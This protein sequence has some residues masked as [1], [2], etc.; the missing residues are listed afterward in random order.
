ML[1]TLDKSDVTIREFTV[2]KTWNFNQ[3]NISSYGIVLQHGVSGS[4]TFDYNGDVNSDGT[5]KR[6]IFNSIKHLFYSDYNENSAL[7]PIDNQ[8]ISLHKLAFVTRSITT[9][10]KVLNI[11]TI[12]IGEGIKQGT[13]SLVSG[14]VTIVDDKNYNLKVSGTNTYIG[15]IFYELGQVIITHTGSLYQN[16]TNSFEVSLKGIHKIYE[17]EVLCTVLESEFNFPTNPTAFESES[18]CYLGIISGSITRP[19]I[20]SIGLYDDN[21]E[22]LAVGKFPRAIQKDDYLDMSFLLRFDF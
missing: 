4:G 21:N 5:Y 15:N 7:D 3:S 8:Y 13:F 18:T 9:D 19:F 6:L 17:Y 1:K 20:T 10:V 2:N 11:P 14:S 12:V 22:L 16:L